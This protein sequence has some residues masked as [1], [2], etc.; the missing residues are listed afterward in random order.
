MLSLPCDSTLTFRCS[1]V[2]PGRVAA[3][4]SFWGKV[5]QAVG[6]CL[7][8]SAHDGHLARITRNGCMYIKYVA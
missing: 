5:Q 4:A 8:N 1:A 6:G 7:P 3:Q 2:L